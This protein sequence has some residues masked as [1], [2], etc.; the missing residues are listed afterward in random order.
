MLNPR[1][2]RERLAA[3]AFERFNVASLFVAD[4]PVLALYALGRLSGTVVDIGHDGVAVAAVVDGG[5]VA[6]GCR[7]VPAGGAA[8]D[9][10]LAAALAARGIAPPPPGLLRLAKHALLAQEVGTGVKHTLPDG[11]VLE[12]TADDAR[13]ARAA[14]LAPA[15]PHEP[16]VADAIV[17]CAGAAEDAASRRAAV[18]GLAVVGGGCRAAGVPAALAEAAATTC[19]HIAPPP[20]AHAPT[21]MPG[22]T[23]AAA[24]WCG[25][26]V[27]SRVVF[28]SGQAVTR[29]EYDE[30]GPSVVHRK[31]TP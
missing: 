27:L 22:G 30:S 21:Y 6:P 11:T 24:T 20:L 4:A 1:R 8:A 10:A 9:A 31:C 23:L 17:L 16:T 26:A 3:L 12:L 2:D 19:A 14:L 25:G 29:G 18:D 15:D 5:V 28:S 7:R 13:V